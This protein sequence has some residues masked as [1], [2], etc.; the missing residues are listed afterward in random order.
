[1]SNILYLLFAFQFMQQ[2]PQNLPGPQQPHQMVS[3]FTAPN[4]QVYTASL[5]QGEA[6]A[7][8]LGGMSREEMSRH[9]YE[10]LTQRKVSS[11]HFFGNCTLPE[12]CLN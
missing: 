6:P 12:L 10:T 1:M 4:A 8:D 7:K 9:L 3:D 11:S 2:Q 5:A